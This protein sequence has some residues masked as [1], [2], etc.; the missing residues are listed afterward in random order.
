MPFE[1][2]ILIRKGCL[3]RWGSTRSLSAGNPNVPHSA[4]AMT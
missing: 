3:L 2:G 4:L 1:V